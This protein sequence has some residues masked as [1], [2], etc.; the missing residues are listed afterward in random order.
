V[1]RDVKSDNVFY[2]VAPVLLG[3]T[4][5]PTNEVGG[6]VCVRARVGV[7]VCLTQSRSHSLDA[8]ACPCSNWVTL[9]CARVIVLFAA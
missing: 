5:M 7:C 6:V 8:A 3:E 2:R 4:L 9:V 1:H